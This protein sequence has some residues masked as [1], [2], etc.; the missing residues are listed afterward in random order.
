[1]FLWTFTGGAICPYG[2]A[3]SSWKGLGGRNR[4]CWRV[5]NGQIVSVKLL[6][7][8]PAVAR[9]WL[10]SVIFCQALLLLTLNSRAQMFGF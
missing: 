9:G 7:A 2:D 10:R 5:Q 1:M 8:V 4:R 3:V 6:L